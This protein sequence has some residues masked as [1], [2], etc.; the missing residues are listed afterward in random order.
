MKT[1]MTLN[2][3]EEYFKNN[4][5]DD[6][7]ALTYVTG[8]QAYFEYS[9]ADENDNIHLELEITAEHDIPPKG[10]DATNI[11]AILAATV[12]ASMASVPLLAESIK[13]EQ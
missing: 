4:P 7:S 13:A 9:A 10:V 1:S 3:M 5:T 12:F 2:E 8:F 11:A 6:S